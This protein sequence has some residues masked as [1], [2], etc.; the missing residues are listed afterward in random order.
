MKKKMSCEECAFNFDGICAAKN[1]GMTIDN[2]ILCED[3]KMSIDYWDEL[4]KKGYDQDKIDIYD[5]TKEY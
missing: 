3:W 1:Y 2:L 5:F 4:Y